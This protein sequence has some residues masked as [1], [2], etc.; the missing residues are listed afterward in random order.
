MTVRPAI[1]WTPSRSGHE[2]VGAVTAAVWVVAGVLGEGTR[3]SVGRFGPG[4][5]RTAEGRLALGVGVG[6][7][8]RR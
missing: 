8:V 2:P 3:C 5:R 4:V 1:V 7:G 6:V